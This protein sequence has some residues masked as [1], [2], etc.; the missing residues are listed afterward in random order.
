MTEDDQ[1]PAIVDLSQ[2]RQQRLHA[3]HEARLAKV[4]AAFEKALPLPKSSKSK[5]ARKGR[6][7]PPKR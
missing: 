4:R 5:N 3:I 2:A 7:K 6:K 1:S